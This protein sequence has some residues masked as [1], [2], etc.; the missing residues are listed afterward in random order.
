MNALLGAAVKADRESARVAPPAPPPL[1]FAG[2][3]ARNPSSSFCAAADDVP[4]WHAR[5]QRRTL[6]AA[7]TCVAISAMAAITSS[8]A[9]SFS[10]AR[11]W[12][13]ATWGSPPVRKSKAAM[14]S[15]EA[16][17]Y[18]LAYDRPFGATDDPADAARRDSRRPTRA[19]SPVHF[20]LVTTSLIKSNIAGTLRSRA[21]PDMA[22]YT[23]GGPIPS[24]GATVS[25][26]APMPPVVSF[27]F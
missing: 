9:A 22:R 23:C 19:G 14:E 13:M 5:R 16:L 6:G 7:S 15:I 4:G 17:A 11:R 26:P 24:R 2:R 18:P 27:S 3:L 12:S 25:T 20:A 1:L 21:L 8:T 10:R